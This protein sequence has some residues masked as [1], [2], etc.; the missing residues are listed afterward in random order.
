EISS[1]IIAEGQPMIPLLIEAYK[2]DERWLI[3]QPRDNYSVR[4]EPQ[5][6]YSLAYR[7]LQRSWPGMPLYSLRGEG[8]AIRRPLAEKLMAEWQSVERL[9]LAERLYRNILSP[10][11]A[12][13]SA[14][15]ALASLLEPAISGGRISYEAGDITLLI[16]QID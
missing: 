13:W 16:D 9:P 6:V 1:A 5:R 4:G 2:S 11:V 7:L 14:A 8:A 15:N 10:R 12:S 3:N